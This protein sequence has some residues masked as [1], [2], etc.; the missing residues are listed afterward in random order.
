MSL[1]SIRHFSSIM[2]GQSLFPGILQEASQAKKDTMW[3]EFPNI[4][5]VDQQKQSI[6]PTDIYLYVPSF[7]ETR[8]QTAVR[9]QR[10]PGQR[11]RSPKQV[12]PPPPPAKPSPVKP[13]PVKE[14]PPEESEHPREIVMQD[15]DGEPWILRCV[16]NLKSEDGL[17]VVCEQCGC[18]QHA[19]CI[20][21]NNHTIPEKYVCDVCQNKKIR[22]RCG[23]NMS[24]R[25]AI[26]KC[27]QCGNYVHKRCENLGY[28][29][30][31]KG[32]FVC[33]YCGR[34]NFHYE[35]ACIPQ[36]I[37]LDPNQVTFSAPKIEDLL[38]DFSNS[39][40]TDFI[41]NE[42][43]DQSL[44]VREFC[45]LAYDKFRSYFY[46]AHPRYQT[47]SSKKKRNR[48]VISFLTALK[49]LCKTFYGISE[50]MFIS[51]FNSLINADIYV[52]HKFSPDKVE[53]DCDFT[54]NALCELPR[55]NQIVKFTTQPRPASLR[56]T[57]DGVVSATDLAS[58]QFICVTEGLIGDLEEFNVE[59]KVDASWFQ[60]TDTRFVLDA[61]RIPTS[62]LHLMPRSIYG[63]CSIKLFQYNG[64]VMAGLFALRN[65]LATSP[66]DPPSVIKAGTPLT[67]GI[68]W[69]PAVIDDVSR[70]LSWTFSD[71]EESSAPPE[72]KIHRASSAGSLALHEAPQYSAAEATKLKKQQ[73][74]RLKEIEQGKKKQRRKPR[75]K[76]PNAPTELSLFPL[77]MSDNP[78]DLFF[79]VVDD[80]E[81]IQQEALQVVATIGAIHV[82]VE[83]APKRPVSTGA[84]SAK[85]K[86]S[87]SAEG[88]LGRG[89]PRTPEISEPSPNDSEDEGTATGEVSDD[90]EVQKPKP[91]AKPANESSS[92]ADEEVKEK[93]QQSED[94]TVTKIESDNAD[95]EKTTEKVVEQE[96]PAEKEQQS[97]KTDE[98]EEVKL[99]D[100]EAVNKIV[101]SVRNDT[102]YL[103]FKMNNPAEEMKSLLGL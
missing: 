36:N 72:P 80:L 6:S 26:I 12:P 78:G 93:E 69:I 62:I 68:D 59:D 65:H 58:D 73:A 84:T 40:F 89:R 1:L 37:H 49:Y 46:I 79:T 50:D 77:M 100:D 13:S 70:W 15:E 29:M 60:I 2:L 18:W 75:S 4:V 38:Q 64:S 67:L 21:L 92:S 53:K 54:E 103:P 8:K 32:D 34:S 83:A 90:E 61:S 7:G 3:T 101:L 44:N 91:A 56:K 74:K 81:D 28:G 55:M 19:I 30:M 52:P 102:K 88:R 35:K 99:F 97:E 86:H 39:P 20:G 85:M 96:K 41:K 51:I 27:S 10:S 98:P 94:P 14:P 95:E 25:F 33:Y 43:A 48:L 22:C 9:T 45:E 5:K 66:D 87:S 63:N 57:D 16:C 47:N 24:F 23:K 42:I 82:R 71:E 76:L 17:L 31:P 11:G